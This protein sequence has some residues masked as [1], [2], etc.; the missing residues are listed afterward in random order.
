MRLITD[1]RELN[2]CHGIQKTQHRELGRGAENHP[3][4]RNRLGGHIGPERVLS[5]FNGAQKYPTLD[6]IPTGFLKRI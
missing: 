4:T 6:E 5:P 1:L 3:G 2:K